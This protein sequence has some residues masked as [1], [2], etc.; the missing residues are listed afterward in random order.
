[1]EKQTTLKEAVFVDEPY[2]QCVMCKS[3]TEYSRSTPIG[4]RQYYIEGAGQL[5]RKCYYKIYGN[6]EQE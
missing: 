6:K 4:E 1:M 2:E 5:C 3:Q